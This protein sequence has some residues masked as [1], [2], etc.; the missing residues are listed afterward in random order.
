MASKSCC[1]YLKT[2]LEVHCTALFSRASL[3]NKLGGKAERVAA[4]TYRAERCTRPT[5]PRLPQLQECLAGGGEAARDL[6]GGGEA[7]GDLSCDG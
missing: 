6:A 7:A 2:V 5:R 1:I 3:G 4:L